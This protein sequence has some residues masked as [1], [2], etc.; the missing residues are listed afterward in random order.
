MVLEVLALLQHCALIESKKPSQVRLADEPLP[1]LVSFSDQVLDLPNSIGYSQFSQ[2]EQKLV[3]RV[4][5]PD[6]RRAG[7]HHWP[8][9]PPTGVSGPA[10]PVACEIHEGDTDPVLLAG[11]PAAD[12]IS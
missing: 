5:Y 12:A 3:D 8:R 6:L 11:R 7:A 2:V 1:G 9:R 4:D 10:D